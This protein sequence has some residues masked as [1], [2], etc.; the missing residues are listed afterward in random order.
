M[1]K[2]LHVHTLVE[3]TKTEK[4]I[5]LK[6]DKHINKVCLGNGTVKKIKEV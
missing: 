3:I 1:N 6:L 4:E 5:R 2:F